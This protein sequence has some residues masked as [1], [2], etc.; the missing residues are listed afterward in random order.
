[1]TQFGEV[2]G[3]L[4]A[5]AD[6]SPCVDRGQ[7]VVCMQDGQAHDAI[8]EELSTTLNASHEQP[9]AVCFGDCGLRKG[10]D[11]CDYAK[12]SA[13]HGSATYEYVCCSCGHRFMSGDGPVNTEMDEDWY[14]IRCPKCGSGRYADASKVKVICAA[15]DNAKAAVDEDLCGSLKVGGGSP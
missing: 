9:I 10:S 2:A 1:M 15:D 13:E 12:Y 8:E 14:R 7:N 4:S 11:E 5:R 6:S 3:T